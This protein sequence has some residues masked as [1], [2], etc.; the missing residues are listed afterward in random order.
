MKR[1]IHS[2]ASDAWLRVGLGLALCVGL[3]TG[4]WAGQVRMELTPNVVRMGESADLRIVF[5]NL[6]RAPAPELPP[7]SGLRLSGPGVERS[8]SMQT[9]NGRMEQTQQIAYRFTVIPLQPGDYTIGPYTYEH[10]G[11][12]YELPAQTLRVVL[13][14]GETGRPDEARQLSDLVFA[15][16]S[17][18]RDH[19]YVNEP[20]TLTISIYSRD[21]NVGRDMSLMN[22]PDTG[23]Q[24]QPW[25]ELRSV[26][27]VVRGDVYDVR[28]YQA[29]VRPLTSGTL[30]FDPDL[31]IQLLVPRA[32]RRHS[33]WDDA[34]FGGGFSNMEA[35]PLELDVEPVTV[36]VRSLP[37]EGRPEG[38]TG[39]VGRFSFDVH[40]HP[41]ENIQPGDPISLTMRIEGEG[42]MD[43]VGPPA[44]EDSD[45]FRVY[46]PRVTQSE[47][48]RSGTRGRK[49]YE[50]V[51]IP[52]TGESGEVPALV[53]SYFDPDAETFR[54]ITRG[55]TVLDL[56][57]AAVT[58]GRRVRADDVGD[59][60]TRIIGE[61]IAYLKPPPVR[62][63]RID[64]PLP[65]TGV[66]FWGLHAVP[67][68]L[69]VV[70]FGWARHQRR[71]ESDHALARRYRAPKRARAGL[72]EAERAIQAD[73]DQA[74]FDGL[75]RA[76]SGYFGDR[77]NW[78]SGAIAGD[79]VVA[80][81][82]TQGLEPTHLDQIQRVFD[83]CDQRRFAGAQV[84][85]DEMRQ[86]LQDTRTLLKAC[87][88]VRT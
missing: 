17:V 62:W 53:F 55:P 35:H 8:F 13:P 68:I 2:P 1:V 3:A 56:A 65:L 61:D 14:S 45:L 85:V 70:V 63:A 20:F 60:R 78:S 49:T 15:R 5:E 87:E 37:M 31:R 81:F 29:L 64:D 6:D 32:Q 34:F 24:L 41:R 27:E 67:L 26:R 28:R 46:P 59:R 51:I 11:Q 42:N 74:F 33:R 82:R 86:L 77:L 72:R 58:E 10:N 69:T 50:Q 44:L 57:E 9:V 73:D 84:S 25:Q 80:A 21:V 22:M 38:F 47:V 19:V 52:R 48:D 75:W 43:T 83:A 71:L 76:L 18:T 66:W 12:T 88:R 40:V 23:I 36:T 16:L 30:T 39:G 7:I 54:S 79:E 4:T